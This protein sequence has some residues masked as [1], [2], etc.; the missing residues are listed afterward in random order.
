MKIGTVIPY[1]KKIQKMY[2][3]RDT[4]LDFCWHQHFS[5]VISK[6]CYIKKYIVFLC[7]IS[8]SFNF[9]W[10]FKDCLIN[11]VAIL[12][13]SAKM[14]SLG[15]V[16]IKVLWTKVYDVIIYFHEISNKILSHDPNYIVDMVMWPKFG[17]SS[18][19]V[20]ELIR[21]FFWGVVLVQVQ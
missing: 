21:S 1:L 20:R 10:V 16:K 4:L 2:E 15:L 7:I 13:M 11:M 12:M 9:F 19:S 3:P 14:A 8:N 17:N 18:I 5:P 6:F